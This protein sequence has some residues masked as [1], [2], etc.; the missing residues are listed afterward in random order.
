MKYCRIC[1][2][3]LGPPLI[4]ISKPSL[5]S[6]LA[7]MEINTDIYV[8]KDCTHAQSPDLPNIFKSGDQKTTPS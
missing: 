6:N 8:C 4:S 5:T 7:K 2:S 3:K 1:C